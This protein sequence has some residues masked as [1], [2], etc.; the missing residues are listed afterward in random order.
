MCQGCDGSMKSAAPG[1][2]VRLD[3]DNEQAYKPGPPAVECAGTS[4]RDLSDMMTRTYPAKPGQAP[5]QA[6]FAF[7]GVWSGVGA[8]TGLMSLENAG[9]AFIG[10]RN[11]RHDRRQAYGSE[12]LR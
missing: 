11:C 10:G 4:E 6:A 2:F 5:A 12:V 3:F 9:V 7:G 8:G 1:R